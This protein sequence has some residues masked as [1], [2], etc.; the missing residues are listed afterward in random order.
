MFSRSVSYH[1][2][3]SVSAHRREGISN[4]SPSLWIWEWAV[5]HRGCARFPWAG[6]SK[7]KSSASSGATSCGMCHAM[8]FIEIKESL[9]EEQ[10]D[11]RMPAA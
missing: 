9:G 8:P 4:N 11:G 7:A 6:L 5:E 2:P 1:M 3:L 10:M